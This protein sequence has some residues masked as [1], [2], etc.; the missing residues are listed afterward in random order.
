MPH[1]F[2]IFSI[3][4]RKALSAIVLLIP[5]LLSPPL[6]AVSVGDPAT[7]FTLPTI[8][9]HPATTLSLSELQG[10]VVYLDFWASWCPPCRISFPFMEQLQDDFSTQGF[11]VVAISL[12]QEQK[13]IDHFLKNF[14][15]EL[16]ILH[17]SSGETATHYDLLAMPTSYLIDTK[18]I[19]RSIHYGFHEGIA[20][21]IHKEIEVLLAE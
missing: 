19:I 21:T 17:D 9:G 14:S 6:L 20:S 4:A 11:K 18:G 2:S 16:T 12:D 8:Q 13:S 1:P 15:K 7:H 3:Q 5:L 10:K